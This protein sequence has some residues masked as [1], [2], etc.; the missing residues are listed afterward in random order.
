MESLYHNPILTAILTVT[1][2]LLIA[3]SG[4][5]IYMLNAPPIVIEKDLTDIKTAYG[6]GAAG[7]SLGPLI[8]INPTDENTRYRVLRH[9]YQH[10]MQ[11]AILSP[12]GFAF[13]YLWEQHVMGKPYQE[14][15]FELDA[16]RAEVD[17]LEFRIF[18][19]NSKKILEVSP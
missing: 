8:Y 4:F 11:N 12:L 16:Y 18:D 17:R 9:E 15:W 1:A 5:Q 2:F 3:N 7:Y 6:R 10:Y 14:N 19:L 13:C